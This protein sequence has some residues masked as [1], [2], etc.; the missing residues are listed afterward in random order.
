MQMQGCGFQATHPPISSR[1][2]QNPQT[3]ERERAIQE[4]V[5]NTLKQI[6]DDVQ[7]GSCNIDLSE[8]EIQLLNT[9][10]RENAMDLWNSYLENKLHEAESLRE[11]F[12]IS[13]QDRESIRQEQ[14]SIRL[15]NE[16][17]KKTHKMQM[18]TLDQ[19]GKYIREEN[20]RR[21]EEANRCFFSSLF[22]SIL[23]F[24]K[25]LLGM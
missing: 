6:Q 11:D 16:D 13:R 21:E 23:D 22:H 1:Y 17:I 10:T 15:E 5:F 18:E 19:L 20:K 25:W 14:A 4:Y 7:R 8:R 2:P 24:F 3:N 9:L 12:E